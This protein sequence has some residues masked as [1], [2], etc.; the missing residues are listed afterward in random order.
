MHALFAEY[1]EWERRQFPEEAMQLGDYRYAD[2]IT[3][4]EDQLRQ[5]LPDSLVQPTP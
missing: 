4:D 1:D 3:I 2:R 5:A